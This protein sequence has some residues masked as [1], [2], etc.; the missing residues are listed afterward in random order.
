MSFGKPASEMNEWVDT[1]GTVDV[2]GVRIHQLT[3]DNFFNLLNRIIQNHRKALIASVNVNAINLAYEY[4]WFRQFLNNSDYAFCDGA[5]VVLGAQI[6]GQYLPQ[7]FTS[8][9]W[10]W[11][12]AAY[13][14]KQG[15]TFYFL[16][17]RSGI[18][19]KAAFRLRDRYPN[20]QIIGIQHGYFDKTLRSKE[21][22]LIIQDINQLKPNILLVG[23]GMPVQERWLMEN[24][25]RLEVNAAITLGAVFDYISGELKRAP[26][27]FNQ[28]GLEWL[29]RLII[30]PRRLWRRYL[31]GNPVFLWRIFLQRIGVHRLHK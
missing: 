11:D 21:N 16:G 5:G 28:H 10:M 2:L 27:W 25:D 20:L 18:A 14:E 17:A 15:F 3:V 30:E 23:F 26:S 19:E 24:W 9:D 13:A 8:A 6:L 1:I 31:I 29:G 12:L 7:R 4:K 22:E